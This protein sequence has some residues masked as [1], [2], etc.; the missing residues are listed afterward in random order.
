M[1]ITQTILRKHGF[2]EGCDGCGRKRSG[3]RQ[4]RAR[5]PECRTRIREAMM[6]DEVDKEKWEKKDE[7]INWR[8]AEDMER[9]LKEVK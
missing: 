7:R 8:T 1:K 5:N 4:A 6:E 2:T 9:V 3:F